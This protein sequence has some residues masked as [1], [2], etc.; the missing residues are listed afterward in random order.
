MAKR[1]FDGY[2]GGMRV[3]GID[4]GT[5]K[6]GWGVVEREGTRVRHVAHGTLRMP[7]GELA[8]RLGRL[9]EASRRQGP[10]EGGREEV[11]G[12]RLGGDIANVLPVE[13]ALLSDA[14]TEDLLTGQVQEVEK[15]AWFLSASLER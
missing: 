8:D 12:V 5:I 11:A 14:D 7:K 1:G 15:G 2:K 4:P 3:L 6:L 9:E 13:L 10:T